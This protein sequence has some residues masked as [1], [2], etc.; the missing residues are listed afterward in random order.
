[1]SQRMKEMN[2][3][4]EKELFSFVTFDKAASESVA[5]SGYSYWGSTFK[6]FLKSWVTRAV[7]IFLAALLLFTF[8][9]PLLPG[10]KDPTEIFIDPETGHQYRNVAPG[11]E[12]WFGTNIIGQDLWARIWSG[13]RTSLFIAVVSVL[14]TTVL[15]IV[16]GALWGYVRFLDPLITEIYNVINNVPTTILQTLLAYVL[17]PGLKTIII[18]MCMTGWVG[19]AKW[20]RNLIIIIRDREYNLASRCLGTP[21]HRVIT[22][23]LLPQVVSVVMMDMALSIPGVIGSEVWLTYIGLGLPVD[24]PSLGNLVDEGRQVMM[25]PSQ[26]YQLIY[27]ALIVGAVTI[28]FYVLGNKFADASDPRNHV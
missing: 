25:N 9:Q 18:C 19:T 6:L 24:T 22:K 20:I 17:R 8:I 16:V 11:K 14:I 5:Y 1:M 26:M 4:S 28:C 27:P 15:G 10:Q 21:T 13:T 7:L 23:N 2:Q 3:M 12:F